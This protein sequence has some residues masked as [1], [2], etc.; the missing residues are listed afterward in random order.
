MSWLSSWCLTAFS[1]SSRQARRS[2]WWRGREL[3]ASVVHFGMVM[4]TLLLVGLAMS[5]PGR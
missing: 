4:T 2:P 5:A 3:L 1:R